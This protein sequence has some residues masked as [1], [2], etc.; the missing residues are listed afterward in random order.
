MDILVQIVFLLLALYSENI[1]LARASDDDVTNK[2]GARG[3]IKPP[4]LALGDTVNASS[5]DIQKLYEQASNVSAM[6]YLLFGAAEPLSLAHGSSNA[7]LP[8]LTPDILR[9]YALWPQRANS[10]VVREL[11]KMSWS[12]YGS[13]QTLQAC[14][15]EMYK[16]LRA[17]FSWVRNNIPLRLQ[18]I[19]GQPLASA[20]WPDMGPVDLAATVAGALS[21]SGSLNNTAAL[22]FRSCGMIA[23]DIAALVPSIS[24]ALADLHKDIA[25]LQNV[26]KTIY[27]SNWSRNQSHNGAGYVPEPSM[28]RRLQQTN[29]FV[30]TMPPD[31]FKPA[32]PATVPKVLVPLVFHIMMYRNNDSSIGPANYDQAQLFI[33]RLVRQA[34]LMAKP[35]NFQFFVKE[36]RNDPEKYPNLLLLSRPT[37]LNIPHCNQGFSQC[38]RLQDYAPTIV[39][40]WPRSINILVAS[41]STSGDSAVGY[42]P[43]TP[44]S[45]FD[46]KQGYV[47]I[48]WDTVSTSSLNSVVYYNYGAVTLLHE[49][50]H[51]LGLVHTFGAKNTG[52]CSDDDYVIDT[53][54]SLGDVFTASFYSTAVTYCLGIFWK[55]Y[56]GRWDSIYQVASTRVG[57]PEA[58][59]NAWADSCPENPGYDELGNYMTYSPNVC[60]AALGHFTLGQ[61]QRAHYVSAE[62]NPILYTW[63]QYYAATA[64]PPSSPLPEEYMDICRYSDSGCSCKSNWT[65]N[66]VQYSYCSQVTAN[67]SSLMCEIENPATCTSCKGRSSCIQKC[68]GNATVQICDA[69]T[70]PGYT[71]PPS[72]PPPPPR[73][74]SPPPFPPPPPPLNVPD[75]CKVS[76]SGC[77]CRSTWSFKL[78]GYVFFT[79]YC[80]NPDNGARFWCMVSPSCPT[81]SVQPYQDCSPE[82]TKNSCPR[83]LVTFSTTRIPPSP[84]PSPPP[85]PPSPPS[86]PPRP[87]RPPRPPPSPWPSPKKPRQPRKPPSPPLPPPP[88]A[89]NP[90]RK[91][92]RPSPTPK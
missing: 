74:P 9:F 26:T 41:D 7:L 43:Q 4:F 71:A 36:V 35:T 53:P 80:T 31:T 40:D 16:S 58:D 72:P 25:M 3:I 28:R 8:Y 51:Y 87:P 88:G 46:P 73:R 55:Q 60:Y 90:P 30:Y 85:P 11:Y 34:N 49:V 56:A 47:W 15:H 45:D 64:A 24:T 50:F 2:Q 84:L 92:S 37:W 63:G 38:T 42:V 62:M 52:K 12:L 79:S 69:P 32:A 75:K 44:P 82:L 39:S 83:Q 10:S 78:S 23:G 54:S 59:M 6:A 68:N 76:I 91:S 18:E 19:P 20:V 1:Q 14:N 86:K 70:F 17:I 89:P 33:S 21:S 27:N 48:S 61:I 65:Y 66:G 67:S 81:F 22:L 5:V 13:S 57:I 29:G 77:A